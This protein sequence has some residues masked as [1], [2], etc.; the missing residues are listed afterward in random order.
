MD[1]NRGRN[2]AVL[3]GTDCSQQLWNRAMAFRYRPDQSVE[4]LLPAEADVKTRST[5]DIDA[6][7][8]IDD[9]VGYRYDASH[10]VAFRR[11][12][13]ELHSMRPMVSI[14]L[15]SESQWPQ[16]QPNSVEWSSDS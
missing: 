16:N 2:S 7:N 1:A 4:P 8:P 5:A 13:Q 9:V 14:A 3:V 15:S 10:R 11:L 12:P 6:K